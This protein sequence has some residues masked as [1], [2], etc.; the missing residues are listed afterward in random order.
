MRHRR[1]FTTL[2]AAPAIALV[3]L[4][5]IDPAAAQAD[6]SPPSIAQAA[7]MS[8]AVFVATTLDPVEGTDNTFEV[9]AS[10]IYKGSP[11]AFLTVRGGFYEDAAFLKA[12]RQYLFFA[13]KPRGVWVAMGCGATRPISSRV[14]AQVDRALGPATPLRV[15]GTPDPATPDSGP[16]ESPT[17]TPDPGPKT[18]EAA[19][20]D[21]SDSDTWVWVGAGVLLMAGAGGVAAVRRSRRW[22]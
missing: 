22:T 3:G 7:A 9:R 20:E 10:D 17:A 18:S 21:G 4:V 8:D 2:I 19:A 11:G 16:T 15:P 5:A 13:S 6:C 1:R 14:I 12:D